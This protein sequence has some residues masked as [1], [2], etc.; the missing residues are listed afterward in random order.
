MLAAAALT[1]PNPTAV[2]TKNKVYL[3]CI[4]PVLH[5]NPYRRNACKFRQINGG[6]DWD[7]TIWCRRHTSPTQS[8][9]ALCA[10]SK[11]QTAVECRLE[12]I[13]WRDSTWAW[14]QGPGWRCCC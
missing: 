9:V 10:C 11:R 14:C 6:S 3:F 2:T 13:R 4:A 7:M 5:D 8:F 12:G 1:M